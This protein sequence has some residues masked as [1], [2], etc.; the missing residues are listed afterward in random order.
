[1]AIAMV[2]ADL[3]G[4]NIIL[5]EKCVL[6][7]PAYICLD[8]QGFYSIHKCLEDLQYMLFSAHTTKALGLRVCVKGPQNNPPPPKL[9]LPPPPSPVL[10]FLDPPRLFNEV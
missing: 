1:M 5:D 4:I 6:Y 2:I 10:N 3:Q 9:F 7:S 8:A